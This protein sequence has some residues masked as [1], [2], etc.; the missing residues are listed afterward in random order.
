MRP[1]AIERMGYYPTDDPV[2]EIIRT[3]LKPSVEKGRLFDPCAGEGKAA[4]TLG[5]GLNCET[6]GVELSPDRAEKAQ[7]V[8]D[9]VY[10]APW[11]SCVLSDESVTWLY[12]NP[13]YE[14]DRFEG[15]KRL[16]WDF[17]KTT[18]SKLMRGGLLT[19]IIPQKILGMIEIA[20]L[21]AGHYEAITVYRFPDG[22]YE[23]FKQVVVLAYKRKLYQPPTDKEVLSLQSLATEELEPIEIAVEPIYELLAAPSRGANGKPIVFK[24]TDWEPEEVVEATMEAGVQ[25]T[26]EWLDLIHPTRGLTQLAQ[27]VM[28]LKKGHIAMLMASGMMGTVRLTDEDGKPMLIKGRVIKVVEKTEQPDTKDADAVIETFKDRFVTTVAVL[29]QDG[30][31][32]IQDVKGLSDFMKAHGE[33]IAAHVLETYKPL[34]N[35]DPTPKEIAV[36]D[37]IGTQRKPLP[38]QERAGLLPAQRHAAAALARS[39]RKNGVANCQAEM[40]SGK[41]TIGSAVIELLNAYPAIVI[42]P[43]HLVPKWIREIEEVIPGAHARELRRIGR[44]SD[45]AYDVNDVRDFLD[46]YHQTSETA[47]RTGGSKPKW[48]AIVAH[49]SAKFGTGWQPA[50]VWRKT[51][52]PLTGKVV[53][54]CACPSCGKVVTAEKD[55]FVI[56][57][58]DLNEL[59][60]KRQFCR[61]HVPGWELDPDGRIKLDANGDPVWG[62]HACKTPLFEFAGARRHSIADYIAKHAQGKFKLLIAD[63]SHQFKS[64]SSDRGVAFHQLVTAAKWTL[65]LTGTFFGGKSTSIFWLLHRLNHGVRRDFAFHD[66]KR[67]ARLYGVL[68]TTRRRRR[69]DDADEDGVYTGNRRYRNQAKEQPG[70]SPAI[71][72]R[73]LDTTIFLSLKD[74]NLALPAYKEEVVALDMLDDQ[75]RQYHSMD[76][77]LKQLAVQSSR[78]LSTWLQWSL[79]RPNSAF[80]DEVVVVDEM[81]GENGKS[82]RK[83]PLMELPAI[84]PNGH[85][86][87]PK[88]NWLADFCKLERQQGRKVLIYVRQTGTRDI[89]DRVQMPLQA[90]GL[91]V[92]ILGGNVDPRKREEWIAKRVNTID[93]LICNPR[94]VETGLDLVQFST[95]VFFEIEY[96]L[97]TL[98]QSVRRVWRLGQTQPVKAIFSVYSTAMEATALALMGKKMKAAQLVYGDEVG[99]AIVPEEEGDFLTQLARDVLDG[100]KLSDLQTLFADDLQVSHNPMGSL[101]TPS[102]VIITGPKVMTWDDWVSQKTVVVRRTRRK[103]VAP[104][105]QM[106]LG[107]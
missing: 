17:L 30:I 20:R 34:Y 22:L 68:E 98:W 38:G 35:L 96:S 9:K 8:M 90:N 78:Y 37:A 47:K 29:R 25:N 27:P 94:L 11:Q 4:S 67:W 5:K 56:P 14:F 62:S 26:S 77:G 55:G 88:E 51:R 49:T 81:D 10:Q 2:V 12:L 46:Q 82:V 39:I 42:C 58:T 93:A 57:V 52:D 105:G 18:T 69:D 99:G 48:I 95:V 89:Q 72:S 33:K 65:T 6:W 103:E 107:F 41:T 53:D 3:Y 40:G 13:P 36:L 91:R 23:K 64:K 80:R 79:A 84:N 70:V 97:Y 100:A 75:G 73:L 106:G 102:A 16:E 44:N 21:L 15:Q 31:Q 28:P 43:P 101:T 32:I 45:D 59:A 85:K 24:R 63:E 86:W 104:E 87:L 54:A 74:L 60:E 92:S 71:V 61:N 1:P 7:N 76:S 66:E 19:Y 50:V 83:V